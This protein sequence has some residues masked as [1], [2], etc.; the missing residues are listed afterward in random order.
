ML[1]QGRVAVVTGASRGIGRAIAEALAQK[2][3]NLL[4][5]AKNS[6]SE[7]ERISNQFSENYGV[8]S[9]GIVGNLRDRQF[10]ERVISKANT[11]LGL[12]DV[13]VNNA[14]TISRSD[15]LDTNGDEDWSEVIDVNLNAPMILAKAC[16]KS[17]LPK[18]SGSIINVTSQM[19][20]K[21]HL[22][23]HP[24]YEVSKA[25]LTALTRHLAAKYGDCNIRINNIAPGSIDTDLP[26]SM[27]ED[28]RKMIQSSIPMRRLGDVTE[29]AKAAVFLASEESSYITG[30]TIHVGGGSF[31][32]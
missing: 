2:G 1:L 19:A 28:W 13:L 26:R 9:I 29:V 16:L 30:T 25:G 3:F 31:L 8:R 22:G 15:F 12:V 11:E 6:E 10:C 18:K 27:S 14:G 20:Y 4:I 17:M 24:S 7:L 5:T 23:A 32:P 21:P